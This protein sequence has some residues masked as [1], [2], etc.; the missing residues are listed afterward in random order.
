MD[1]LIYLMRPK[2]STAVSITNEWNILTHICNDNSGIVRYISGKIANNGPT[3]QD[4]SEIFQPF[5]REHLVSVFSLVICIE[6]VCK[7]FICIE[8]VCIE[9]VYKKFVCKKSVSVC[10]VRGPNSCSRMRTS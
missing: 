5:V 7:E 3:G 10:R 6:F 2:V 8:F 1:S 4:R 9:F